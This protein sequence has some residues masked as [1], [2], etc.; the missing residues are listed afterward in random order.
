MELDVVIDVVCP[1]CFVG[2][3]QLEK[4][5]AERPDVITE[6]RY[7]PYQL[8]PDTPTGGVDRKTY[9]DRKF[10]EN[11]EQLLVMRKHLRNT[12]EAL[13]INFDFESDCIIA[14]TLDAHRLIRW[15][16]SEGLQSKVAEGIMVRYFEENKFIGDH[17]LLREVAEEA[18]MDG[19]L[20]TELLKTDRDVDLVKA[21]VANA[22]RMGITGVPFFIFN[23]KHA[24]SG[25]QD[26]SVLVNV[27]DQIQAQVAAE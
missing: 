2:K 10:G 23:G 6:V 16:M 7:R 26:A 18:G 8:G 13:G 1:W 22:S 14:N 5:M 20:V 15:S 27:I 12:G 19:D 21:E 3:R 24:V 17:G 11:S 25:A 4:A 9:Y